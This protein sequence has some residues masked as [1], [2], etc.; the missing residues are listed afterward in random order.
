MI[1]IKSFKYLLA[2]G[3]IVILIFSSC[4][5]V[6]NGKTVSHLDTILIVDTIKNSEVLYEPEDLQVDTLSVHDRLYEGGVFHSHIYLD[7]AESYDKGIDT[8]ILQLI[9][10]VCAVSV[11]PDTTWINQQQR[12]M[13]DDWNE[14]VFDNQYYQQLATDT[15]EALNIPTYFVPRRANRYIKFIKAD[16]STFMIDLTKMKDAWGLILFNKI[17]DPVLWSSKDID[18]EIKEIYKK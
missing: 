1:V 18:L 15:L 9:T 7:F 11:I 3:L 4:Q 14:I 5:N 16:N 12:E 17:D 10:E 6:Q 8:S 2:F 13:G